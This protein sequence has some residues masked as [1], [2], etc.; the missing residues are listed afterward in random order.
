MEINRLPYELHLLTLRLWREWLDNE[1]FEW[2]GELKNTSTGEIR[3]FRDS[4]S[5]Y[6]AM[7]ALLESLPQDG[8]DNLG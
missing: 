2:R 6:R 4:A 5:L 3:Y 7:L 1:Q 8:D